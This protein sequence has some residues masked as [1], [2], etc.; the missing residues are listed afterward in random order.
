MDARSQ[1]LSSAFTHHRPL[2]AAETLAVADLQGLLAGREDPFSRGTLPRHITAS[3]LVFD[4][5]RSLLLL[6]LHR[7]L[8]RWLQPGGHVEAGE[9]PEDAALRETHEETGVEVHHP[10]SGPS[11][12]HLDEHAG[13]DAHVHLDLRY[14]LLADS[15]APTLTSGEH[16]GRGP[17]ATLRWV[18]LPEAAALS[19][20]SLARAVEALR[21]RLNDGRSPNDG[22]RT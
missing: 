1:R 16:T 7:R 22:S 18:P 19:D 11:I 6:H 2:D 13:P 10:P 15:E 14:L 21:R 12:V 5:Q 3:A 20:A 4:P 9:R 17:G 8:E